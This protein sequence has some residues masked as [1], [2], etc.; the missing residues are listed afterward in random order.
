MYGKLDMQKP[1]SSEQV[2]RLVRKL[3]T[4]DKQNLYWFTEGIKAKANSLHRG[5]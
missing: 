2:I 5:K 4:K 1:L 3:S